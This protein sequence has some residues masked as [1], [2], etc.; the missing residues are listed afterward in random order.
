MHFLNSEDMVLVIDSQVAGISGDMILSSLVDLGANDSKIISGVLKVQNY[1]PDSK[2]NHM[3]FEKVKKHGIASTQLKLDLSEN[4]HERKASEIK[5]CIISLIS[6]ISLS[7]SAKKFAE[8]SIDL[9]INSE[10]LVHNEPHN[11]VHFHE[12]ASIDTVID[13]VGTAIALD[14]LNLFSE[15]IISTPVAIGGGTFSFSHGTTSNPAGAILEIFK[16]S[17]IITKGGPVSDEMTT[18][19]GA[20]I[21]KSLVNSCSIFYPVMKI[22]SIGYGAGKRDYPDFS[23]SLKLVL[24]KNDK[25]IYFDTVTILETNVD[26]VSGE[27]LGN[28]IEKVMSEGAKDVTISNAITKKGRPTNIISIICDESTVSQITELLFSETGTLGIRRRVSDRI[29]LPR[30]LHSLTVKINNINFTIQYKLSD[31]KNKKFK[32]EFDDIFSVSKS[33]GI[34]FQET[35][36]ILRQKISEAL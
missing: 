28:L 13:I 31:K 9:L 15:Q 24:G 33:L 12:A 32:I 4:F 36:L 1:F 10:S 16:N 3:S 29:I 21:L 23:N 5:S 14:D 27:I 26:D 2:I 11:S 8:S 25:S 20:C 19:T 18:P 35:E 30:T 6:E 22:S 34:P 17:E 7:V